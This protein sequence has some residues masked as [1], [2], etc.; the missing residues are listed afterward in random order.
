MWKA[1]ST[2]NIF[3]CNTGSSNLKFSLFEAE[4]ELLLTEGG[5]DWTPPTRLVLRRRGQ[6]EIHEDLQLRL[7]ADP[8]S[9]IFD[10][11]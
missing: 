8:V 10:D 1:T 9:R 6:Q 3:V 4:N 11:L 5:I 7:H 2:M